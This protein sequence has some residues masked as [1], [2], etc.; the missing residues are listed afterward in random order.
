VT[1]SRP[2]EVTF[3]MADL[4]GFTALTEAHGDAQAMDV[5]TRFMEIVEASL[6][7]PARVVERIGDAVLVVA[8][9]PAA[10]LE[11]ALGLR[12]A[13]EHEPQFPLV[14]IGLHAG[15]AL[16]RAGSYFGGTI[17]LTARV[18]AHARAGQILCTESVCPAAGGR[19]DVALES[20]GPVKF[21]NVAD[22]VAVFEVVA[23]AG[24][25]AAAI[26]PVCRMRVDPATA[27]ARLPYRGR[28]FYFCSL[29]CARAFAAHP[30]AYAGD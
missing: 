23:S 19:V 16:E 15:A 8:E 6:R 9:D 5:V 3:L 26:D 21:K 30:Q 11:T 28:A 20:L 24:A 25:P 14:R 27:P 1:A 29:D 2:V 10:A 17:N 22:P 4:S 18:A 12:A 7:P 13:I